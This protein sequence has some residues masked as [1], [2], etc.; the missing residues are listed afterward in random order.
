MNVR[1][2]KRVR[3]EVE[4]PEGERGGGGVHTQHHEIKAH[5]IM[6]EKLT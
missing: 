1:K 5:E 2:K 4:G 6:K 3:V